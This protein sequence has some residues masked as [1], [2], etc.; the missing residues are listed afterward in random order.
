MTVVSVT[1]LNI[2]DH[3]KIFDLVF[4]RRVYCERSLCFNKLLSIAINTSEWNYSAFGLVYILYI[5][6][7]VRVMQ[8]YHLQF[9]V[10]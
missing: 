8:N 5:A 1:F 9:T 6:V 10:S 2:V 3:V 7:S 4:D